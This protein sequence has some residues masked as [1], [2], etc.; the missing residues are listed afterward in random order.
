MYQL[1]IYVYVYC[2]A[3]KSH[4]VCMGEC[5]PHG[6]PHKLDILKI[7]NPHENASCTIDK[8]IGFGILLPSG[9]LT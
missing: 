2:K 5:S 4:Q 7:V 8:N 3:R 9:K 1:C 6:T